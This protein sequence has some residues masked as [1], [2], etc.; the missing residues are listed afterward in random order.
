MH[1]TVLVSMIP[2]LVAGVLSL[3][4]VVYG[5]T[6]RQARGTRELAISAFIAA[7]WTGVN[8]MEFTGTDEAA[9]VFWSSFRYIGYN[10]SPLCWMLLVF[11]FTGNLQYLR[12]RNLVVV[13]LVPLLLSAVVFFDG[14][15]GLVRRAMTMKWDGE[16]P[17]LSYRLGPLFSVLYA[18]AYG[19][20]FTILGFLLATAGDKGPHFQKQAIYFQLAFG[21][22][23]LSLFAYT[24]GLASIRHHD[25]TSI[26][27][28]L[29]LGVVWWGLFRRRIFQIPSVA[30]AA[31]FQQMADGVLVVDKD[32][33]LIDVNESARS[34]FDLHSP[35]LAG[36]NLREAVAGL[37]QVTSPALDGTW[38]REIVLRIDHPSGDR[39]I[40]LNLSRLMDRR[41][42]PAWVILAND[43]TE[44]KRAR[45]RILVQ[46][47][48]LAV[49]AERDRL[50][51]ELHDSLG[52]VLSFAVIQTDTAR[53]EIGKANYTRADSFLSRLADILRETHEDLRSFVRG[54]RAAYG[55]APFADLLEREAER[56]RQSREID[57]SVSVVPRDTELSPMEKTQVVAILKESL[58]NIAKHA[59]ASRVLI[60][61]VALPSGY[62]LTVEDDGVG[63]APDRGSIQGSGMSIMGERASTI[64]GTVDLASKT[65]GG[66]RLVLSWRPVGEETNENLDR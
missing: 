11:R 34:L 47:E 46:R 12:G 22:Y 41:Y 49:A 48:E 26:I 36:A 35:R 29:S 6:H 9:L 50:S 64:A 30:R 14:S 45:E 15:L 23:F 1:D 32:W 10:F 33:N 5:L 59:K 38:R 56:F 58:N 16:V 40:E 62:R 66:T 8:A 57:V 27:Y 13:S 63:M 28:S 52:Q 7:V 65:E 20:T 61:F 55:N 39:S 51:M 17:Y 24:T 42:E 3:G 31:V 54:L 43:V 2:F 60:D 44:L 4:M 37:A 21:L 19:V 18:Y 53:R 25:F